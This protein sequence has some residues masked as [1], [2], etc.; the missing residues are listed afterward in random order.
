METEEILNMFKTDEQPLSALAEKIVK[1][2]AMMEE[3]DIEAKTLRQEL[4]S[5]METGG[6]D[7]FKTANGLSVSLNRTTKISKAPDA[8]ES[9]VF[10]WLRGNGYGDIIKLVVDSRTLS[11]TLSDH[12]DQGKDLPSLFTQTP[13]T[14]LRFNNRTKF[15]KGH[16]Q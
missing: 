1:I 8:D 2:E 12:V 14:S 11:K 15:Q 5:A 3:L 7:A 6:Q 9:H 4:I 16:A 13:I 10:G